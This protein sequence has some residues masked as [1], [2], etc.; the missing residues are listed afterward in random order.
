MEKEILE[1]LEEVTGKVGI[2]YKDLNTGYEYSHNGDLKLD[3]AS[4]I[5]IPILITVLKAVEE[6]SLNKSDKY[7]VTKEVQVPGCGALGYMNPGVEVTLEDLST[8]MIILSDNTATNMLVDIVGIDSVN[9]VISTMGLKNTRLERKM[10]DEEEAKKGKKNIISVNDMGVILNKI[11]DNTCISEG[12]SKEIVE[13][14]SKQLL[15]AKIPHLLPE[16]TKIAHKTGE[17]SGGT[18]DVGIIYGE[19]PFIFCFGSDETNV[20]KAEAA[21]RKLALLFYENSNK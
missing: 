7:E 17:I 13:I 16:G 4:V 5:K 10:F 1:L 19:N 11:Y 3:A 9:E 2:Y 21:L 12:V 15:W 14:M 8:L 20:P 18:H 6:G